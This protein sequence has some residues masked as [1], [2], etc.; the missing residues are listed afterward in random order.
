MTNYRATFLCAPNCKLSRGFAVRNARRRFSLV[1]LATSACIGF[2]WAAPAQAATHEVVFFCRADAN[3]NLVWFDI[4]DP[5]VRGTLNVTNAPYVNN[6][7]L[8]GAAI[9]LARNRLIYDIDGE[10][11][12]YAISLAGL[13]LI[14]NA[15]TPVIATNLG[16]WDSAG[17]NAGYRKTDGQVYYHPNGATG[18]ELRRLSFGPAGE[19]TGFTV[20]GNFSGPT[21]ITQGDI[22][23]DASGSIWLAGVNQN[24][25]SRLWNYDPTTLNP[26]STLSMPHV[27][28]GLAFN[29]AGNTLYGDLRATGQY[30][31]FQPDDRCVHDDSL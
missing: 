25:D 30:G 21:A 19:I 17:D 15:A 11:T 8:N 2:A 3:A 6:A 9:D 7:P 10:G 31:I 5:T 12:G 13:Q 16:I 27:Y 28:S 4:N 20:V 22:A 14:P 23:F 24:G 1:L 26:I 29:A 18:T